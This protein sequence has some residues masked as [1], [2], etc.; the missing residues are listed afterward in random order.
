MKDS[1]QVKTY[2][3]PSC[4]SCGEHD[5]GEAAANP[6]VEEQGHVET[7]EWRGTILAGPAEDLM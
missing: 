2:Q 3:L 4:P 1:R 5:E 6:L 7:E